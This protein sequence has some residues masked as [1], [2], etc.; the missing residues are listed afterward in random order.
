MKV[1]CSSECGPGLVIQNRTC[2]S[3]DNVCPASEETR[4]DACEAYDCQ[5][6][7]L[8]QRYSFEQILLYFVL[9]AAISKLILL[10]II[11]WKD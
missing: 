2:T 7:V 9:P 1:D 6:T 8:S 11:I 3:K 4:V 10:G 5:N